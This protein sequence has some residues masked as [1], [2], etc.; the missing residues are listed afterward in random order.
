VIGLPFDQASAALQQQ[1]FAVSRIDVESD[2]PKD[3]VVDQ[4][5]SGQAQR[6]STIRLSVSKGPKMSRVPDV[7]SQDEES[8]RTTLESA[9]FHVRVQR[10]EVTD[11]G[12]GGIV[13]SQ[14]PTG[15]TRAEQGSVVT[16]T[17]GQFTAFSPPPPEP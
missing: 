9:G 8:A 5:P 16:I 15:G 17:V 6:G 11:P 4:S 12:L 1:G 10:E 3:T 2:Q 13:L 14:S 7:T